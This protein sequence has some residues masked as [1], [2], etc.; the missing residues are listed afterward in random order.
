M[1]ITAVLEAVRT[2]PAPLEV[3]SDSTYV[4]NCW[5]DGWWRRWQEKGWIN[6]QRKPVANR[7]LWEQLVPYFARPRDDLVLEWVKGH[8][9][10]PMNDLVD[11]LAVEASTTQQARRG[12]S[13]PSLDS[14]GPPDT[15]GSVASVVGDRDRRLPD[16]RLVVVTGHRPPELG[17]YDPNPTSDRVR[18]T[19][20]DILRAKRSL[21]PD[22]VVLTGLQLGA[23]QLGADAAVEAGLP[24]VAIVPYP[25]PDRVWPTASRGRYATLLG[26]AA[27]SVLL[28]R[29]LPET[30]QKVAGAM[31][32]R[33]AWLG[34]Q[35]DEAIVVWDG[36]DA[37][38]GRQVRLLQD[39]LGEED[40]WILTP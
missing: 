20:A 28:E 21:H 7:D 8:S 14:L 3:R 19:L 4:V 22:L 27:T 31:A 13:P 34:R 11:R 29:K 24:Y 15:V 18:R 23:E 36:A 32:R 33:D 17:G 2:L 9:E 25:D 37:A 39:R 38:I 5:R 26:Q 35:A 1:E 16:G 40:V 12:D 30:R 10:D 6:S